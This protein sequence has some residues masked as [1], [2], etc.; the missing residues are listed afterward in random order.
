M[1]A[2]LFVIAAPSG[3]GK[4][5]LVNELVRRNP[6]LV[7]SVSYT[8]RL[9]RPNEIDGRD[10]FFVS[11]EQFHELD[12]EGELLESALVFDNYYGTSRSQVEQH[13]AGGRNVVLEIDWQGARQVRVARPDCVSVFILP[14]SRD[15]L[16]ERLRGRRTDSEHVIARRLAEA[17]GDMSHWNEFDFCVVND[18]LE[19]AVAELEAIVAGEGRGNRCDT[20]AL[21]GRIAGILAGDRAPSH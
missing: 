13:L 19:Q 21:R 5:T 6:A 4:T 12:R 11:E 9:R 20:P 1:P 3:A 2:R 14:P 17:L 15:A 8:T 16:A 10:Y 7:F 18:D